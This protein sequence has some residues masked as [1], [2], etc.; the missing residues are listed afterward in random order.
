MD[1]LV[2]RPNDLTPTQYAALL[3]MINPS[4]WEVDRW[5]NKRPPTG[6]SLA[7][8]LGYKTGAYAYRLIEGLVEKGYIDANL[9]P[10][11]K[12]NGM[13]KTLTMKGN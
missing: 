3:F 7:R 11:D 12:C 2:T 10:T 8:K 9:I 6:Y 13:D 1:Y 4:N 5:G